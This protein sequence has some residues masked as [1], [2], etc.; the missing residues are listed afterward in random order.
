M[1]VSERNVLDRRSFIKGMLAAGATVTV[2]ACTPLPSPTVAPGAA[3]VPPTV[4][5]PAWIHPKS[6]V[7]AAPGY[8][9]AMLTWKYG[10]TVKWLPPA[11]YLENDASVALAKVSKAQLMLV[12]ERMCT[13]RV[14]ETTM[15]D[16]SLGGYPLG[17]TGTA[18]KL[19]PGVYGG[20]HMRVGQ[21]AE[22]TAIGTLC[23]RADDY[24]VATHAAHHDMA[25]RGADAKRMTA[26][27]FMRKTGANKGYGGTM[28]LCFADLG[29]LGANPVVGAN[30]PLAAGAAWSAKVRKSGQ[31]AVSYIGDGAQNSRHWFNTVRSSV[32]YKLPAIFVNENNFT[33]MGNPIASLSPSPYLADYGVGLGLPCV[34]ADGNSVADVYFKGKELCDRARA[35]EGPSHLEVM[36]WRWY[37]HSGFAGAKA[38]VDAAW[39]LPYRTDDEVRAWLSRD[40]IVLYADWLALK[41]FATKAETDA[42]MAKVKTVQVEA[43]EFALA[44]PL[45]TPEDGC[46]NVW[47]LTERVPATQFFEHV[48]IAPK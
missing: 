3:V 43:I 32:N 5:G 40:P 24:F 38:G 2:A 21:E 48:V 20:G 28:H 46:A 12:F 8:G 42:I 23:T 4:S 6:L 15:K 36:T 19:A 45:T 44:S 22:A 37:D 17:A 33:G 39:G 35:L 26:E 14:F 47:T 18:Q 29:F 34:V 7:R 31:M 9:G 27:F 13:S 10:D 30:P 25:G 41:G 11:K 1:K 16:T